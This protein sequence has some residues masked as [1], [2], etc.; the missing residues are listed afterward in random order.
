MKHITSKK[1]FGV[2]MLALA[3][4][5]TLSLGGIALAADGKSTIS[6]E[7]I[8]AI[9]NTT[10]DA[11]QV[12]S[13]FTSV[14]N[15]VRSSV[16]GINNYQVSRSN[17]YYYYGF[18]F[19]FGN[20]GRDQGGE[21]LYGTGSGVAVTAYGHVLTN[22]HVV[23]GAS[24]ITVTVEGGDKEYD[25]TLVSYDEDQDIAVL[26]VKDLPVSPV[27]LGDSDALQVGE[28]A[29]VIGNPL[30]ETFA[31]TVTVG[32]V[33]AL[34]RQIT[35]TSYDMYGR[36]TKITNSMIQVDAAIN[37]GNSGGGMFN[38]LGQLMGIPARKYSGNM[39]SGASVDNIG[40]C[41]PV[42]VAKPLIKDALQK[43]GSDTG[44]NNGTRSAGAS[45]ADRPMLGVTVTTVSNSNGVLP[46]GALVIEV[47]DNSNASR[48]GIQKGDVIVS[49]DD[50]VISSSSQL[51]S[52]IQKYA[53]GD[54]MSVKIY[55]A[56]GMD[57]AI[58]EDRIDLS[59]VGEG[60]YITVT[61]TLRGASA[62]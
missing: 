11:A 6:N 10:T 24:R 43:Y 19:G 50:T 17:N 26:L 49:V 61:V 36:R 38:T 37:S 58:Q 9:I 21:R 55:R 41:I 39:L 13:P 54:T 48:A 2:M 16:V 27:P 53:E 32:V 60:D 20:D 29:I 52:T 8:D 3:L 18:G 42:N 28:W 30:S 31:R 1:H 59:E 15:S 51:V 14:A 45:S 23:D 40:M 57:N 35:D 33:S 44:I 62:A 12:E 25:A 46:N 47:S 5:L 56:P 7:E 4:T 34:D 22:Y